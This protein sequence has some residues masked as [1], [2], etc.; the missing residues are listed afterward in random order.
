MIY[1]STLN[2]GHTVEVILSVLLQKAKVMVEPI[3]GRVD[4]A[5]ATETV[6]SGSIPGR[7]KPT[8]IYCFPA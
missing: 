6:D 2:D 7:V 8:G 1:Y 4:T 3:S 5:F